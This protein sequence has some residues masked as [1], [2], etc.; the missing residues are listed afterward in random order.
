[1]TVYNHVILR[2]EATKNLFLYKLN[3]TVLGAAFVRAVGGDGNMRTLAYRGE[4]GLGNTLLYQCSHNGLRTFLGQRIVHLIGAGGVA[5]ALDLE[6]KAGIL[7][8][9]L[10]DTVDFHH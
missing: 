8:H 7:L 3:S 4:A 6:L 2:S 1:M 5:V 10:G 9:Q